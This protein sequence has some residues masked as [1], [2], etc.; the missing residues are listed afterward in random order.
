MPRPGYA[1]TRLGC[2]ANDRPLRMYPPG[3]GGMSVDYWLF[4]YM[5]MLT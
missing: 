2:P 5:R 4:L 3:P 1:Y